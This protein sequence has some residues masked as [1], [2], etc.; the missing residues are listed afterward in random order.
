MLIPESHSRTEISVR[1]KDIRSQYSKPG[2][3]PRTPYFSCPREPVLVVKCD[4]NREFDGSS[5]RIAFR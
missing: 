4:R 2:S 1:P 3:D 5:E